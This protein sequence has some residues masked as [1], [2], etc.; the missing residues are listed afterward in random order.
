MG[1]TKSQVVVLLERIAEEM[2]CEED[3]KTVLRHAAYVK[4][5]AW[6]EIMAELRA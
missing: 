4:H 1:C 3:R 2:V 6:K 5:G